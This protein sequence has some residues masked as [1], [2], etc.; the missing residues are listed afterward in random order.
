MD[1]MKVKEYEAALVERQKKIDAA[2]ESAWKEIQLAATKN[3]NK[4]EESARERNEAPCNVCGKTEYVLKYRD[5]S[6]SIH[7]ET[8]G[9]FSLFGGSI[10]GY[11]DGETHTSPVLSCRNCGNER[12]VEIAE[13]VSDYEL[14]EKQYGAIIIFTYKATDWLQEKGLEIAR[15]LQDH[16]LFAKDYHRPSEYTDSQMNKMGLYSKFPLPEKPSFYWLKTLLNLE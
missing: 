14:L 10:S 6:G 2:V 9:Y 16:M 5:V 13:Y 8:H 15:G 4:R 11:V 1:D 7:G 3:N 12:R